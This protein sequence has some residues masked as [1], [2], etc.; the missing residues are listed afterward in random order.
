MAIE[1]IRIAG[2]QADNLGGSTILFCLGLPGIQWPPTKGI[3]MYGSPG[4]GDRNLQIN[5]SGVFIE[6]K[7]NYEIKNRIPQYNHRISL[8]LPRN[9][10][11]KLQKLLFAFNE[12]FVIRLN[13]L[14]PDF[15]N[16]VRQ[17]QVRLIGDQDNAC[18]VEFIEDY[19]AKPKDMNHYQVNFTCVTEKP[20]YFIV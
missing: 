13:A 4:L 9:E 7:S 1:T 19:G 15:I 8:K 16:G 18:Q 6:Y 5:L 14:N 10:A 3:Y 20:A 12:K 17:P 2:T 11:E